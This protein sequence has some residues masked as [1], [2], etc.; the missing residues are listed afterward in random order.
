[1]KLRTILSLAGITA[2]ATVALAA[3]SSTS[4]SSN[5]SSSEA[6]KKETIVMGTVGTTKPF[7]YRDENGEL[8][9][10][11]IELAR[12]IFDGSDQYELTFETTDG[13]GQFPG[14][15][16]GRF[17]LLGNN[18]SYTKERGEKYLYSYPTASTPS[19][20]AVPKNTD[21]QSYDDIGGHS[22]QVVTGTTTA[23]QLEEYNTQHTDKP[24]EINYTGEKIT[25]IL[26]NVNDG[27]YDF[28]IFDAPTVNAIIADQN[29]T[30]LKTI[31]L[32]AA[33][34]PFIYYVFS[35]DNTALQSFVNDRIKALNEDGT[36]A[37]LTEQFFGKD[38]A[39]TA[40]ELDVPN[41]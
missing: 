19:V 11:D 5:T 6:D 38:Y 29:L 10:F 41:E 30:N 22:T 31:E 23:A 34:K 28:K 2:L 18:T 35:S 15:D 9:G 12:A 24:V 16:S 33:E 13:S 40:E 27:K 8:T 17:D 37:K 39:P 26:T 32:E 7:S 20:L 3:C 1:M 4:S 36:I 21:I 25:Q 14:L